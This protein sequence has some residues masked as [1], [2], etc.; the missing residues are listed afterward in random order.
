MIA[1]VGSRRSKG[2]NRT[3]SRAAPTN[4]AAA[5][6]AASAMPHGRPSSV[7]KVKKK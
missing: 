6:V 7:A 5:S 3:R 2:R 4:A 1:T